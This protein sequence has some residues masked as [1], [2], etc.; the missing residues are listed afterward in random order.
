MKRKRKLKYK[1]TNYWS[2]RM[3]IVGGKLLYRVCLH[4]SMTI[5]ILAKSK[6]AHGTETHNLDESLAK[7]EG[8]QQW[9]QHVFLRECIVF[10][11]K[12]HVTSKE[13]LPILSTQRNIFRIFS[14]RVVY[15]IFN[16][17]QF[18]HKIIFRIFLTFILQNNPCEF[19]I[20]IHKKL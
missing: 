15:E 5:T 16:F 3:K 17:M 11:K 4:V 2:L 19:F 10:L 14:T 6:H 20:E 7:V 13:K 9:P 8:D 18:D 12:L 1:Q